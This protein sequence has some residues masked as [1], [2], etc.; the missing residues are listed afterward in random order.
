MI[1]C[2]IAHTAAHGW[3]KEK[4]MKVIKRIEQLIAELQYISKKYCDNCHEFLCEEC[5]MEW[6]GENESN[7]ER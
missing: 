2:A 4:R 7:S 3:W 6:R 1:F 5:R